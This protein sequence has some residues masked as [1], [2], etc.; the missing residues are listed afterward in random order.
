MF[1][2]LKKIILSDT[3]SKLTVT[4]ADYPAAPLML[5]LA[6]FWSV[7]QLSLILAIF[8]KD[9][10]V[11][12]WMSKRKVMMLFAIWLAG[13]TIGS[14]FTK[15]GAFEVYVGQDRVWSSIQ[16]GR[17]PNLQDLTAAFKTVGIS[18]KAPTA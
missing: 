6:D 18:L 8:L 11:P 4:S 9:N 10:V 5:L 16:E 15:T 12:S 2:Q 1:V 17:K 7:M 13:S 3:S 14:V